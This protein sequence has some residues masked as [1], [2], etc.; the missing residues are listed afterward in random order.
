MLAMGLMGLSGCGTNAPTKAAQAE[1]II[2]TTVNDGVRV[3]VPMINAG[4]LTRKQ[5]DQFNTAYDAYY[6]SQQL[7]KAAIE[8]VNSASPTATVDDI[9]RAQS[10]VNSAEQSLLSI[11]N[12]II[13]H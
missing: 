11:I 1:Q 6:N 8:K 9:S 3:I 5:C 10:A 7:V 2:I 12:S 13:P 4:K